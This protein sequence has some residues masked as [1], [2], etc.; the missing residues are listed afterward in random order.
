[1]PTFPVKTKL[2]NFPLKAENFKS[3]QAKNI[4]VKKQISLVCFC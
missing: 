2:G 4:F 3:K 1:M